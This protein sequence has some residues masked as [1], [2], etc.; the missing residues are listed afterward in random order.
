MC[1]WPEGCQEDLNHCSTLLPMVMY[2]DKQATRETLDGAPGIHRVPP[3]SLKLPIHVFL[4]CVFS[5]HL[6]TFLW[7]C[8]KRRKETMWRERKCKFLEKLHF[9]LK[10]HMKRRLFLMTEAADHS[11]IICQSTLPAVET[12]WSVHYANT[13]NRGTQ[14]R[15]RAALFSLC[16]LLPV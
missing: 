2:L 15:S 9:S 13:N 11:W 16:S 14:F 4:T 1:T 8:M 6:S 12:W 10:R 5:L 7:G 3:K